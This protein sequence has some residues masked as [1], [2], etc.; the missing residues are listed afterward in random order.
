MGVINTSATRDTR[1]MD[2]G[3]AVSLRTQ[4]VHF[5]K[6]GKHER[7]IEDIR[8]V[9]ERASPMVKYTTER[10]DALRSFMGTEW[11]LEQETKTETPITT[12]RTSGATFP[13]KSLAIDR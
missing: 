7:Q 5:I 12:T 6:N 4:F 3:G 10:I 1:E 2:D 13:R 8:E 9:G 11:K